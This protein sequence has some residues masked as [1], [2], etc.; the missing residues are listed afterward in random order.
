MTAIQQAL[1][2]TKK[3]MDAVLNAKV[4]GLSDMTSYLAASA[5]KGLRALL[6]LTAAVN[7]DDNISDDV[8]KAAAALELMH[9][10]T[11]IHDDVIDHASTRRGIPAL[12]QKFGT[13]SAVICGDYLLSQSMF[14]FANMDAGRIDKEKDYTVSIQRVSRA[15]S[16]VCRGEYMQHLN[17][18]NL[19]MHLFTYLRI[20]SGKTAALFY[21]AAYIGGTLGGEPPKVVQDL[22]RFGRYLGIIFQILDDCKDYEWTQNQALKPVGS[23]IK[24][25]VVTLPLL[26]AMWNNPQ[27]RII[28]KEIIAAKSD[29]DDFIQSV[30]TA[31]GT[32]EARAL[33][34]RYVHKAEQTLVDVLPKKRDA[35][36]EILGKAKGGV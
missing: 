12:H 35:L 22:G 34:A 14:M 32:N 20:I 28:A 25:G 23:D 18:G 9:M 4:P 31:G 1:D 33:A 17:A 15:L 5:G 10:A 24:S 30:L 13:K 16:A 21:T 3:E 27:L 29:T 7:A 26:F 6:L 2:A 8:P 36:L 19:D 11:L